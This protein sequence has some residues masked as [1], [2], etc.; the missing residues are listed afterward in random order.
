MKDFASLLKNRALMLVSVGS[1]FR[2]MT[3]VGL[4][5]F[6][7]VY[8]AYEM[9]YSPFAVGVCLAVMQIAGFAAG[10]IGGHLSDKLGR[11]R[12]VMS[13]MVLSGVMIV[14]MAF[15]GKS[16]AV[17]RCSS[18]WSASSSTRCARC[19]RRGPSSPRRG[20]WPARRGVQFGIQPLGAASRPR[21]SA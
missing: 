4:L 15:A 9:G 7:P 11:K 21:S 19:S 1:S 6:L 16:A 5:T 14:C 3:Q 13:S 10:P 18:R 2:T 17:R 12:V 20:T 8:L